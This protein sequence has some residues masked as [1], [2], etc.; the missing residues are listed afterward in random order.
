[1]KGLVLPGEV[2]E[3]FAVG[4]TVELDLQRQIASPQM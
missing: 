3:G 2:E 4:K 1:M